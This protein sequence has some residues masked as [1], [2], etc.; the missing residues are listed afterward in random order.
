LGIPISCRTSNRTPCFKLSAPG[1]PSQPIIDGR[2]HGHPNLTRQQRPHNLPVARGTRAT[3]PPHLEQRLGCRQLRGQPR[4]PSTTP[5]TRLDVRMGQWSIVVPRR[6]LAASYKDGTSK[7]RRD[8]VVRP[9]RR[10]GD[11]LGPRDG[12]P[13][14][15][16]MFNDWNARGAAYEIPGCSRPWPCSRFVPSRSTP[17]G[18]RP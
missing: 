12:N 9:V 10:H 7:P 13:D 5:T 15:H 6:G 8:R 4:T 16:A 1:Q 11:P 2:N 3:S 18:Y 17:A 14:W